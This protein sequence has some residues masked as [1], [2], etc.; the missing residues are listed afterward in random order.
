MYS[1]EFTMQDLDKSPPR[2]VDRGSH[3][4]KPP[5]RNTAPLLTGRHLLL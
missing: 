3:S 4:G 5:S 1:P 2:G